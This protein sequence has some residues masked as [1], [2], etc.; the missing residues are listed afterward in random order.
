MGPQDVERSVSP[1]VSQGEDAAIAALREKIK[2]KIDVAKL[3]GTFL[4]GLLAFFVG[5]GSDKNSMR[6]PR[7]RAV[8]AFASLASIRS[9][10]SLSQEKLPFRSRC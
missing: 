7:K 10:P 3:L 8:V 4:T 5:I 9:S 6:S 2:S 1:S